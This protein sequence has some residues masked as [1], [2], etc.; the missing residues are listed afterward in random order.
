LGYN[1][2]VP[3]NGDEYM[4]WYIT[5]ITT[6]ITTTIKTTITTKE[7]VEIEIA[8]SVTIIIILSILKYRNEWQPPRNVPKKGRKLEYDKLLLIL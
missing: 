8:G 7:Y 2:F 5:T 4:C 1:F 6:T 3:T